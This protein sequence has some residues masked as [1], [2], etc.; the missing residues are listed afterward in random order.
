[1]SQYGIGG[2]ER[3]KGV[4]GRNEMAMVCVVGKA[5]HKKAVVRN[6]LRSRLK[7]A[8]SLI[9]CRGAVAKEDTA[10]PPATTDNNSQLAIFHPERTHMRLVLNDGVEEKNWI[11]Q[12]TCMQG[13]FFDID[14]AIYFF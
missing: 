3:K 13:C 6:R 8:I 4:K 10:A 7:S 1:M 2:G 9:V 12:G 14:D 11:L 5:T